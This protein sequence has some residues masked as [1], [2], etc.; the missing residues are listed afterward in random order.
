M[1]MASDAMS[2]AKLLSQVGNVCARYLTS[3]K[4]LNSDELRL[5]RT[6]ASL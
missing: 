4:R 3:R 6:Q 1:E 5:H 2:R